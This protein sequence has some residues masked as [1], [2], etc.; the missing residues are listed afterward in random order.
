MRRFVLLA[1][2]LA[3][4]ARP[5]AEFF[6]A[7]IRPVLIA[8]CHSCHDGSKATSGLR[9]DSKD[10]L[11]RGGS[12]GTAVRPG[13]SDGSLLYRAISYRD[14]ML[15]MPPSGKLPDAVVADF[16]QWIDQ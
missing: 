16:R 1:V 12:R 6:E 5:Q 15:K 4:P 2:A 10:G 8:H 7:R 3:S 13:D 11:Q 14:P 9:L